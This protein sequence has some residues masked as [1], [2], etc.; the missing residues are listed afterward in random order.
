MG[1]T[2]MYAAWSSIFHPIN[3][4]YQTLGGTMQSDGTLQGQESVQTITCQNG[5]CPVK[6]PAPG[7]ALVFL[8]NNALEEA[9]SGPTTTFATTVSG[10]QE[11]TATIN[12]SVLAT[13]NGR[14]PI[15][16]H[17]GS[18]SKGK[19]LYSGGIRLAG[20]LPNV[21]VLLSVVSSV[22]VMGRVR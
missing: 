19:M 2:G 22:L 10:N 16:G 9:S 3:R 13:S 7:F 18:T 20:T 14:R 6:I 21:M 12:P 5:V 4:L 15:D 11:N 1:R 8:S 17:L